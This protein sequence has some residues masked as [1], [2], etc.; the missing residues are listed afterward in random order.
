[1]FQE[2]LRQA[3]RANSFHTDDTYTRILSLMGKRRRELARQGLLD[4]L[5]RTGLFTSGI[6]AYSEEGHLISL[7]RSGRKHAG[8]NLATVLDAR[9][10]GLGHPNLMCDALSRNAP[11]GHPVDEGNCLSHA[12]RG[13]VDEYENFPKECRYLLE[14]LSE[15]FGVE[16]ECKE[17]GLTADAR[18]VKHQT[19]SGPVMEEL[20]E[21]MNRQFEEKLVEPNSGLGKAMTYMLKR[22]EKFTRFLEVPGAALENNIVER[23]LKIAIRQ[24]KN[25][26]FY[27]SQRGADVG[28]LFMSLIH[29][30]GLHGV[31]PFDYLTKLMEEA[32]QVEKD[33]GAWMP[34]SYVSTSSIS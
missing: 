7:F 17:D 8:E 18:L 9:P 34:W 30:A 25:S 20:R 4:K 26:L 16:P 22:W 14:S 31:N 32:K 6:I 15:V 5:E 1:M 29:T 10:E 12:R 19:E 21:W 33:P 13:F 2:L 28:D 3:A 23:S 27:R 11:K 24:R